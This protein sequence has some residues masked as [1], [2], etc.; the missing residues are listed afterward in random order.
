MN[1]SALWWLLP[2]LLVAAAFTR[3]GF[4]QWQRAVDKDQ[5]LADLATMADAAPLS[6]N[7][8]L[9][10]PQ[11]RLQRVELN[12]RLVGPTVLL[13]NQLRNGRAG[14]LVLDPLR[15]DGLAADLLVARGWLPLADGVRELPS[16]ERPTDALVLAGFLDL[17]TAAGLSLGQAPAGEIT[18][19][20]LV[21]RIDLD[22][23][24]T[25]LQRPLLPWVLYLDP[26]SAA[27]FERDWS[28]RSLPPERHRGYA[29]Q[30][31]GLAAAVM[32]IYLILVW[33]NRRRPTDQTISMD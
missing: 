14:V 13:D 2:A 28:P 29:V 21:T 15:M 26:S 9:A 33:R 12:G 22:W 24:E 10:L 18:D 8:A 20:L 25:S 17:P 30:W 32:L 5:R 19:P 11:P 6:L 4:W 16:V 27:G 31:W 7:A 1:R 3:L 23:L